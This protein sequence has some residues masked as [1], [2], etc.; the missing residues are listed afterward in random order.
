MEEAKY[1]FNIKFNLSGFDCQFTVRSDEEPGLATLQ[2]APAIL[3]DLEKLGAVGERRWEAAKNGTAAAKETTSKP[4]TKS[5]EH[6]GS[7]TSRPSAKS[8]ALP[9][10][11]AAG[12]VGCLAKDAEAT[13]PLC[14]VIGQVEL[15]GFNL[16]AGGYKQAWKCQACCRWLPEEK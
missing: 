16:K 1:S 10:P 13:C 15:I 3:A 11:A 2:K 4:H 12:Q 8:S 5:D 6:P 14:G 9:L 7:K